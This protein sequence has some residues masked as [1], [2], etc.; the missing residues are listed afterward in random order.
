MNC[1]HNPARAPELP[2]RSKC[3]TTFPPF[4]VFPSRYMTLNPVFPSH[5]SYFHLSSFP[6]TLTE[7]QGVPPLYWY[8]Q[9]F[10]FG[11][12]PRLASRPLI[13]NQPRPTHSVSSVSCG[14]F[15]S[16]GNLKDHLNPSPIS[17]PAFSTS[18]LSHTCPYLRPHRLSFHILPK[19]A[20]GVKVSPS[21][22][23]RSQTASRASAPRV[24]TIDFIIITPTELLTRLDPI[25]SRKPKTVLGHLW[26][27]QYERRWEMRDLKRLWSRSG[28]EAFK[29]T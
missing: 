29:R 12:F 14:P 1:R 22:K 27:T 6:A 19:T 28:S 15:V 10:H 13:A 16:P 18:F 20:R 25:H 17:F 2:P 5:P 11:I 26:V 7:K 21:P 4:F 3:Q 9:S 8:D 23:L 24:T